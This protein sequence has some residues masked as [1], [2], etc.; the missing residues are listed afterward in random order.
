M[1]ELEKL[2]RVC[3]GR[4]CA[5]LYAVVRFSNRFLRQVSEHLPT[6]WS[7]ISHPEINESMLQASCSI[8]LDQNL[9]FRFKHTVSRSS[10]SLAGRVIPK[11]IFVC[12]PDS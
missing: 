11:V 2:P 1:Q 4:C 6:L 7:G 3:S 10:L 8:D 9:A 5:I 12:F